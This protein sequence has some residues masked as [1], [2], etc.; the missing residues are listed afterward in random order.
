MICWE[1]VAYLSDDARRSA[2]FAAL[3]ERVG[4]SP[5]Q[6]L[7]APIET[8]REITRL[9][10]PIAADDRAT[11]LQAAAQLVQDESGGDLSSVLRLPPPKAKKHLMRFPMIGEPGAEKILLFCGNLAVLALESNGL[12][13][14]VRYGIGEERQNYAATHKSV[15]EAMLEQL[16]AD[17]PLLTAAHLLLR[18]HGQDLC[19]RNGPACG[20]CPVRVACCHAKLPPPP[21]E[22]C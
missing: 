18:R 3:R 12:R 21:A 4:L 1:I 14:L 16:P 15:R 13:V 22:S 17:L 8:L 10:G 11:R 6:I 7:V 2:A 9:G 5:H 19:L 20:K